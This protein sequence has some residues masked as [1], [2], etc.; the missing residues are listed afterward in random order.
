MLFVAV[1]IASLLTGQSLY[2]DIS[3]ANN[4]AEMG[5]KP[6]KDAPIKPVKNTIPNDL[7]IIN[8]IGSCEITDLSYTLDTMGLN[9]EILENNGD[10]YFVDIE[11]AGNNVKSWE[12]ATVPVSEGKVKVCYVLIRY[13]HENSG[14]VADLELYETKRKKKINDRK[15]TYN[16]SVGRQQSY[17][18][19]QIT[20]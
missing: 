20:D 15:F 6:K 1:S 16:K 8:L 12:I 7:E 18:A 5:E 11:G 4:F 14:D 3:L 19:V 17:F 10:R 9:F 13:Y 2:T